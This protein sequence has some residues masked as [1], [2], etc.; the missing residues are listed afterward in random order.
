M[1]SLLILL[2]NT[3]LLYPRS[4]I[5]LRVNNLGFTHY[6]TEQLFLLTEDSLGVMG[7]LDR[8]YT[9]IENAIN[10]NNECRQ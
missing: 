8:G 4:N 10:D 2:A 3:Q 7:I 1:T 9:Y 5:E 6:F